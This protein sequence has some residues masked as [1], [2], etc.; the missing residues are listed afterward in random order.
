MLFSVVA[1]INCAAR[2]DLASLE[3]KVDAATS[4][5]SS[6]VIISRITNFWTLPV[7]VIGNVSTNRTYRGILKCVMRPRLDIDQIL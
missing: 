6:L 4:D 3:G 1:W 5:A 7:T 2:Y